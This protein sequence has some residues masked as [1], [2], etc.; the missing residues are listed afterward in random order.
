MGPVTV[1]DA[2]LVPGAGW[3]HSSWAQTLGVPHEVVNLTLGNR[4][5]DGY[6]IQSANARYC[7]VQSFPRPFRGVASKY[8]ES[9]LR[10]FQRVELTGRPWPP[11]SA[12][13]S[14]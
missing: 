10:S 12:W 5:R 4:L 2:V 7:Q 1:P 14:A 11:G 13:P 3:A 8:P 6:R 9:C